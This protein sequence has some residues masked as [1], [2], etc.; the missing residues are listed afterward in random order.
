ML[1]KFSLAE[2]DIVRSVIHCC[3]GNTESF[4]NMS[5]HKPIQRHLK[6]NFWW[7]LRRIRGLSGCYLQQEGRCGYCE[8]AWKADCGWVHC[9]PLL[10]CCWLSF[11]GQ[12]NLCPVDGQIIRESKLTKFLSN[13]LVKSTLLPVT[14]WWNGP[15][16][17][18][19]LLFRDFY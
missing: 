13:R 17:F 15:L 7:S 6:R 8:V 4:V 5:F 2:L 3:H 16:M 11:D 19:C 9:W 10:N 18:A 12:S 1:R 14:V